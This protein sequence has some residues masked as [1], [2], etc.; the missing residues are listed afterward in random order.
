ML[1]DQE[2]KKKRLSFAGLFWKDSSTL[3]HLTKKK[4]IIN[5]NE[6]NNRSL[7]SCL[8]NPNQTLLLLLLLHLHST[9]MA[10]TT[11]TTSSTSNS[12][13]SFG[14]II[15]NNPSSSRLSELGINSW[16]K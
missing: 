8:T 9:S 6:P 5:I 3:C 10:T 14:I 2:K 7:S 4:K 1:T 12:S 16:P 15:E 13:S 11:P